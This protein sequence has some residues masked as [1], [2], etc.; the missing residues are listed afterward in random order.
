MHTSFVGVIS[1]G[2]VIS[3]MFFFFVSP[4]YLFFKRMDFERKK[5]GAEKYVIENENTAVSLIVL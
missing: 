5:H 2:F 4:T 1:S 3:F